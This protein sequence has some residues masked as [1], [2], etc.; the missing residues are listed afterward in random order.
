MIPSTGHLILVV[1]IR[2][3]SR[4]ATQILG[5]TEDSIVPRGVQ[6][7][8]DRAHAFADLVGLVGLEAVQAQFV[9]FGINCN[10]SLAEFVRRAAD[11][12]CD[13]TAVGDE[14]FLEI[15]H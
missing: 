7:G 10:G 5:Y 2:H 12:N 4:E 11:P 14:D 3:S 6:I 8:F 13:L 15:R 9:L 1:L